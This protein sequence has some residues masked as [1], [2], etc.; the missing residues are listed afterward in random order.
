MFWI[1]LW[2]AIHVTPM[3]SQDTVHYYGQALVMAGYSREDAFT[4]ATGLSNSF[5][6][7]HIPNVEVLLDWDLIRPRVLYPL[8]ASPFVAHYGWWGMILTSWLIG[9]AFYGL[10]AW[11]LVRRFGVV[12]ALGAALVMFG[13]QGWFYYAIGPL[14]EGLS[15]LLFGGCLGLIWF[16]RRSKRRLRWLWLVA[17]GLSMVAFSFSRQ[18]ML[19]PAGALAVA[20]LGEWIRSRRMRNSWL[21]P[22]ATVVGVCAAAQVYQLVA[23]PFD[24]VG[25]LRTKVGG[26]TAWQTLLSAPAHLY[27][28]SRFDFFKV[29][30]A[31]PGAA[32]AVALLGTA[33]LVAWRR[34]ECH[35][36]LGAGLAGLVYQAVN[37]STRLEFRYLEPGFIAYALAVGA[38]FAYVAARPRGM[39]GAAD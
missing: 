9:A 3:A 34:V 14:T 37:G 31:D 33:V 26:E 4:M 8:L 1:S 27:E 11:A 10:A 5:E 32:F 39:S 2:R 13:C 23:F 36:A 29:M 22:A 17:A 6:W 12:P 19:I 24:Q 35:L 38:L 15:A 18:A 20:W 30:E 7:Y 21:A 28:S 25:W 16:Y